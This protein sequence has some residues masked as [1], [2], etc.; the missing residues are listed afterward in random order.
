MSLISDI[1]IPLDSGD[2]CVMDRK[3]VDVLN[4]QMIEQNRFVRGLRAYAGFKQ[5]GVEYNRDERA[6][7]EVKYTFK[8]LV[9]L[10]LDGTF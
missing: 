9:K 3:V 5:V 6:A 4:N 1:D 2:F 8:K 10:A 7:G